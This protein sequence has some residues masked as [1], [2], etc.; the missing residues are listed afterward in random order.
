MARKIEVE[1]SEAS[2]EKLSKAAERLGTDISGLLSA[3]SESL[4]SYTGDLVEW[5]LELRVRKENRV[6]AVFDELV[7]YGVEARRGIVNRVLSI[8]KAKGRFELEELTLDPVEPSL[9]IEL[10]ALEGSDLLCD[11]VRINWSLNSVIVE[12][13]YYDIGSEA[14]TGTVSGFNVSYLPDED[15]LV[16]SYT[17]RS[18]TEVPPLHKFDSIVRNI[19]SL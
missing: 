14:R 1:V 12:A 8:L 4:S 7:Y 15:A 10:V 11:R 5:G 2:Y 9:E 3:A 18:L 19:T 17:A 16:V 13:Y 6:Q